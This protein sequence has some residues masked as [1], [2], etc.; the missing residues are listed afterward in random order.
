MKKV[1][2]TMSMALFLFG[3]TVPSLATSSDNADSG[4]QISNIGTGW[5]KTSN[6]AEADYLLSNIGT[7]WSPKSNIGTGWQVSNIGT[8]WSPSS[9]DVEV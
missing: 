7:G 3:S 6:D 2:I 5:S 1:L 8:G 4:W 9:G